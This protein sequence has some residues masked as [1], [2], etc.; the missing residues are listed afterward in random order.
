MNCSNCGASL[1]ADT[2]FCASCGTPVAVQ[3]AP[4]AAPQPQVYNN[5][6]YSNSAPAAPTNGLAITS[7][8]LSI[9]VCT[10]LIGAILG[11]VALSQI[12]RT[13]QQGRGLAIAGIAVGW[14]FS[15]FWLLF[16]IVPAIFA[17]IVGASSYG[18]S[19]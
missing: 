14:A 1:S 18:Y 17:A 8:V 16:I 5:S 12:K 4:A 7:L 11:H 13:G 9:L 19:Y 15:A 10:S 2:S 3:A 6:P